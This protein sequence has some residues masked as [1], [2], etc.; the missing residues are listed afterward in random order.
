MVKTQKLMGL[1]A[2]VSPKD[3][4]KASHIYIAIKTSSHNI[5]VASATLGGRY[6]PEQALR[7]F[8][9]DR[10]RFTPIE[11]GMTLARALKLI[12]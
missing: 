12:G 6:T 8:S 4:G 5:G 2:V 1:T 11:N 9:H 7:A 3:D 10:H